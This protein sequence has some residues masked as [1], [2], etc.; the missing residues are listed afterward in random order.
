MTLLIA[1]GAV[2]SHSFE[3]RRLRPSDR[4]ALLVF[5]FVFLGRW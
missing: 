4:I 3:K 5:A 2:T 1:T